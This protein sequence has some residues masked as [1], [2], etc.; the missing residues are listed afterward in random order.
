MGGNHDHDGNGSESHEHCD[1]KKRAVSRAD[2]TDYHDDNHGDICKTCQAAHPALSQ[3]IATRRTE[4]DELE[5]RTMTLSSKSSDC[6]VTVKR[7]TEQRDE[8]YTEIARA[9]GPHQ[10]SCQSG[11][12]RGERPQE[13]G[14]SW[15]TPFPQ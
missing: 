2:Q 14:H 10:M 1:L 4:I 15:T 7:I 11:V 13:T 12:C 3:Q 9:G 8:L 5:Q 6:R